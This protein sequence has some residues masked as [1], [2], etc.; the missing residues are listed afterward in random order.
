MADLEQPTAARRRRPLHDGQIVVRMVRIALRSN[1]RILSEREVLAEALPNA[2]RKDCE[3]VFRRCL[4]RE[5]NTHVA[6][7][8]VDDAREDLP[9]W[10]YDLR[11]HVGNRRI[12]L[13]VPHSIDEPEL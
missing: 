9:S 4:P 7:I 11:G 2:L 8:R 1:P 3:F 6:D 12:R 10:R 5:A 13:S